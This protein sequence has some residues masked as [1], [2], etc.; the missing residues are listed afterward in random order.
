MSPQE[1]NKEIE[2]INELFKDLEETLENDF[3]ISQSFPEVQ[4]DAPKKE[5]KQLTFF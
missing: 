5:Q 4:I 2:K 1:Y 3:L